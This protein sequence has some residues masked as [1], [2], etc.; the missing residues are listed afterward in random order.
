MP[1]TPSIYPLFLFGVKWAD[2][3]IQYLGSLE[4]PVDSISQAQSTHITHGE[5]M[6]DF[7][8]STG[9]VPPVKRN[10]GK[11]R[12]DYD[13]VLPGELK[14]SATFYSALVTFVNSIHC[15][16]SIAGHE[17]IPNLVHDSILRCMIG[18]KAQH[19]SR[20]RPKS[21]LCQVQVSQF[22]Q[23]LT[24]CPSKLE[25]FATDPFFIHVLEP[26]ISM[27]ESFCQQV[28]NYDYATWWRARNAL[29]QRERV[30]GISRERG[31]DTTITVPKYFED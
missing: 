5:L 3:L 4:W 16:S 27:R 24:R 21:L 10:S 29:T 23:D 9:Q 19:S 25:A 20:F 14:G 6:L 28:P 30:K 12:C 13:Y 11:K 8:F 22:L 26:R 31:N 18:K 7:V 1:D 2:L 15:L 17:L